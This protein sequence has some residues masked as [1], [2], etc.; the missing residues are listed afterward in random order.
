[1]IDTKIDIN[2]VLGLP[3]KIEVTI[4]QRPKKF[5]QFDL[6]VEGDNEFDLR[7]CRAYL[8][9]NTFDNFFECDG[10]TI[11]TNDL[12]ECIKVENTIDYVLS[13]LND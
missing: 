9:V 3:R 5:V 8:N 10:A 6:C 12:G 4:A 1:M 13:A 7:T 11:I 2:E